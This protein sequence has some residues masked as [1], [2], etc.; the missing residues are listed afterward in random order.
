MRLKKPMSKG[1][2]PFDS[3]HHRA[4]CMET[5]VDYIVAGDFHLPKKKALLMRHPVFLYNH[6]R[7]VA[8]Q[9]TG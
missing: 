1:A 9:Y 6:Q 7:H 3:F 5:G 2:F 4:R 8:Q